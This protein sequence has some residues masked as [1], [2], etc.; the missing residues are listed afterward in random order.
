PVGGRRHRQDLGRAACCARIDCSAEE[1]RRR[2]GQGEGACG[3]EI[4][5]VSDQASRSPGHQEAIATEYNVVG[6]AANL[7]SRIEGPNK[8][9]HSAILIAAATAAQLGPDLQ[10]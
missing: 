8:E 9:M 4:R 2:G 5:S 7:A 10:L 3:A 6:E 1:S